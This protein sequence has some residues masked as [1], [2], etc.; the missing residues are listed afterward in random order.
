MASEDSDQVVP[1]FLVIHRLSDLD[2]VDEPVRRQMPAS[3]H[4]LDTTRE[5]LKSSRFD[6]RSGWRSKNGMTVPT[7]SE[8]FETMY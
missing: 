4:H 8:R 6:V 2:D 7:S 1:G 5:L 3:L